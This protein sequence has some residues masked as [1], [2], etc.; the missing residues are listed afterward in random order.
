MK[1]FTI[2][3]LKA[4]LACV[5]TLPVATTSLAQPC[6][7]TF[8]LGCS[9]WNVHDVIVGTFYLDL[10]ASDCTTSDYT[11][12]IANVEAGTATDMSVT[13][14][15]W[16][17]ATVWADLD[18]SG[19]FE[20]AENLYY[21]Y[22]GADPAYTY[23]FSITI[24]ADTPEGT[25]LMRV[26]AGWGTDGF[27]NTS[28]NGYGPCGSYQYGNFVDFTLNVTA[29]QNIVEA[30]AR[31]SLTANPIPAT[32]ELTVSTTSGADGNAVLVLCD[33]A[34][35]IILRSSMQAATTTL[36]LSMLPEG[37]YLLTHSSAA[38]TET[39]RVMK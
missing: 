29:G 31:P 9:L 21:M 4:T 19:S 15:V 28:A 8:D 27:D 39:I 17:G 13:T 30:D 2:S 16:C 6:S 23:N 20:N 14:G 33:M 34:G 36:D 1:Y 11:N 7:P 22:V 35:R 10:T 5:I 38:G 26:L 24:P 3:I 25:Y 32:D 12:S 18:N 37:T